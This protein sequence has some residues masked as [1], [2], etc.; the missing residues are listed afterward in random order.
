MPRPKPG[1]AFS[2]VCDLGFAVGIVT[3]DLP[4]IGSLIWMAEPTF[5]EEPTIEQVQEIEGWRWPVFFPVAAAIRRKIVSPI[6]E[7]SV[8]EGLRQ[9]P[10]LRSRNGR[11]GWTLVKFVDGASQPAGP[12]SD[13]AI[14]RYSVVNDTRLKEMIVSGW[15]PENNW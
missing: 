4:R 11:G 7:V 2:I 1:L 5:D 14:A 8:P 9:F 10:L 3:H 12:A 15:R 6:G 13:P